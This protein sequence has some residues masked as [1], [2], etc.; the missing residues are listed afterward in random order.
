[1][2][3]LICEFCLVSVN[4]SNFWGT[5]HPPKTETA[6]VSYICRYHKSLA[7]NRLNLFL[8]LRWTSIQYCQLFVR[9][10]RWRLV[11][12]PSHTEFSLRVKLC[13]THFELQ[14]K[15][16]QRVSQLVRIFQWPYHKSHRRTA[17]SMYRPSPSSR[18]L[19]CES[20]QS[21][22]HSWGV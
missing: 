22:T 7:T 11:H 6:N 10:N 2:W 16:P 12:L 18:S 21:S 5:S 17:W 4:V 9:K 15:F 8:R 14:A 13:R 3:F 1:M 20:G 19:T